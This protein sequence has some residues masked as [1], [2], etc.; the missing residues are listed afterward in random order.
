M[1]NTENQT[2]VFL[3]LLLELNELQTT[4][5]EENHKRERI[6]EIGRQLPTPV[7]AHHKNITGTT[8]GRKSVA[9][10]M[11]NLCGNC[12]LSIPIADRSTVKDMETLVMCHQCCVVLHPENFKTESAGSAGVAN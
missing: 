6:E 7:F 8:V 11:G 5:G 3:A 12:F 1:N 4:G 2:P 10:L 9:P